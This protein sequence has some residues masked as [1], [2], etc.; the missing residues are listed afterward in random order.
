M[1]TESVLPT[2]TVTAVSTG[3]AN[4]V[5]SRSGPVRSFDLSAPVH[6]VIGQLRTRNAHGF[7]IE[8]LVDVVE[9]PELRLAAATIAELATRGGSLQVTL[10]NPTLEE[11]GLDV[12]GTLPEVEVLFSVSGMN[13]DP[14]QLT[15][16]T[17][18][19]PDSARRA[20]ELVSRRGVRSPKV[21]VWSLR[22]GSQRSLDFGP[23]LEA[24]LARLEAKAA[25]IKAF[26]AEHTLEATVEMVARFVQLPPRLTI[27]PE[28]L[29][30]MMGLGAGLWYDL[31]KRE[32]ID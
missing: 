30:A 23:L 28:H 13:F 20:G 16:Q 2:L 32:E 8:C 31:Y 25:A 12:V 17:G 22:S 7:R 19:V 24:M 26:S 27:R 15:T 18:L 3:P 5:L 1:A 29:V 14:G 9:A 6:D 10:R 21:D 11:R 4:E